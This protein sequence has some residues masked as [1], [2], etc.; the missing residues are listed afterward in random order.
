MVQSTMNTYI[1][2]CRWLALRALLPAA[3]AGACG[4]AKPPAPRGPL[5]KGSAALQVIVEGV[6]GSN[7]HIRCAL[8]DTPDGFP[9]PSPVQNGN[10]AASPTEGASCQFSELPAGTYAVTVYHDANDNQKIDTSVFGA[11]TEGYGATKNKLPAMS[12]PNF[13]ESSVV[14]VDGQTSTERVKLKY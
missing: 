14:L 1:A 7:G 6:S 11:P 4:S 13:A 5:A 9:G 3:L 12:P 10:V 2:S 8:F